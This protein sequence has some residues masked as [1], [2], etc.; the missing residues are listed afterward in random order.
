M[1]K[2]GEIPLQLGT[3]SF[4]LFVCLFIYLLLDLDIYKDKDQVKQ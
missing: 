4:Y 1:K 3:S 2:R